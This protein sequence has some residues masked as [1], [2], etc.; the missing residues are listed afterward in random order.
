MLPALAGALGTM[1]FD[2][3]RMAAA[4]GDGSL[5]AT[6]LAE[7][8][9]RRGAAFRDAH[10]AVGKAVRFAAGKSKTVADLTPGELAEFH[11]AFGT[12]VAD[13]L[14][15]RASVD[16]RASPG[17]SLHSVEDQLRRIDGAVEEIRKSLA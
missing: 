13:I 3:E 16:R 5:L 15:A 14:S 9:V 2:I 8:L 17:P 7:Y 6:D 12:D 1:R 10:E 4:A 11:T